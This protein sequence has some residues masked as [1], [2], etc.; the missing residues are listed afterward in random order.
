MKN[1]PTP[2]PESEHSMSPEAYMRLVQ[3]V[4]NGAKGE[5]FEF[6]CNADARDHLHV[7]RLG[8]VG[9][10]DEGRVGFLCHNLDGSVTTV[11]LSAAEARTAAA[12][13]LNIADELDSLHPLSSFTAPDPEEFDQ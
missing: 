3:R 5:D 2:Q 4:N 9:D 8:D 11:I 10:R 7:T 12:T 1:Q 13:I 6:P